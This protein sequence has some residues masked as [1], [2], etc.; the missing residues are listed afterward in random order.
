MSS[1][2]GL[3]NV[4]TVWSGVVSGRVLPASPQERFQPVERV[5]VQGKRKKEKER[6]FTAFVVEKSVEP[7]LADP[8]F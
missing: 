6:S 4:W 1:I 3:F 8:T 2:Y 5:Q 7:E